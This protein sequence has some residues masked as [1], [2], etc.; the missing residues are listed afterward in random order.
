MIN[1][2]VLMNSSNLINCNYN[3]K[4]NCNKKFLSQTTV[5]LID[6]NVLSTLKLKINCSQRLKP[7][8][9]KVTKFLNEITHPVAF[10][11]MKVL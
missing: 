10:L 8:N 3:Y 9:M 6:T 4:C 1:D 11:H 7:T 2:H 5:L